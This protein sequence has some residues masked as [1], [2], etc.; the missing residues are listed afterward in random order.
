MAATLLDN[1]PLLKVSEAHP[2]WEEDG[3]GVDKNLRFSNISYND[4]QLNLKYSVKLVKDP[5]IFKGTWSM[6]VKPEEQYIPELL[7]LED[8]LIGEGMAAAIGL[9]SSDFGKFKKINT[10][11][12]MNC[13]SI[14]LKTDQNGWWKFESNVLF[15]TEKLKAG[16][17]I[18]INLTPGFFFSE[19]VNDGDQ[20]KYGLYYTL[21]GIEGIEETRP[22]PKKVKQRA[23]PKQVPIEA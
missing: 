14:K 17:V 8:L 22:V 10:L 7:A 19:P 3:F 1:I 6:L 5:S 12:R 9:T 21:N 16:D 18:T 15:G 4:R 20:E 23:A 2:S 13:L 11:T